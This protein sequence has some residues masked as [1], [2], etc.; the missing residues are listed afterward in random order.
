MKT[1]LAEWL[2][3]SKYFIR[4]VNE[5]KY[6]KKLKSLV[7]KIVECDDKDKIRRMLFDIRNSTPLLKSSK[8]RFHQLKSLFRNINDDKLFTCI[9]NHDNKSVLNYVEHI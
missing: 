9:A 2:Y 3:S 1:I 4:L 7:P 8:S 5:D 6:L